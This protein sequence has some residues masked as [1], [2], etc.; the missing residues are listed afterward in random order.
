MISS[1]W[2]AMTHPISIIERSIRH[3]GDRQKAI[4]MPGCV[5]VSHCIAC[6][7]VCYSY[8]IDA[9]LVRSSARFGCCD[10][11][12]ACVVRMTWLRRGDG[13]TTKR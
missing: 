6:S 13:R 10:V 3:L 12:G 7:C 9:W 4:G 11:D 8:G 5:L 1:V 2:P